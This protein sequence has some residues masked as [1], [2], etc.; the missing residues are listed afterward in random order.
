MVVVMRQ[1]PVELPPS[2]YVPGGD[3]T[4]FIGPGAM[5]VGGELLVLELQLSPGAYAPGGSSTSCCIATH[6]H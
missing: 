2:A 4:P 5:R 6:S 3:V 1:L